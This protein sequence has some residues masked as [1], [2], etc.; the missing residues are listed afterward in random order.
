[1]S[2]NS[3]IMEVYMDAFIRLAQAISKSQLIQFTR[4]VLH[5]IRTVFLNPNTTP[6]SHIPICHFGL[7]TS[8]AEKLIPKEER[9]VLAAAFQKHLF[10]LRH[11]SIA[12]IIKRWLLSTMY[13]ALAKACSCMEGL[14]EHGFMAVSPTGNSSSYTVT[15]PMQYR[16]RCATLYMLHTLL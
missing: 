9:E 3:R 2:E 14:I 8:F 4:S 16:K 10:S 13:L 5:S 6:S 12:Y 15:F 7:L 1:V 11:V